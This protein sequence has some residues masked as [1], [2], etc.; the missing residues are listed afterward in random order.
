MGLES[1]FDV[2]FSDVR[3]ALTVCTFVVL[4]STFFVLPCYSVTLDSTTSYTV[5]DD[6][7]KG[8]V[9]VETEPPPLKPWLYAYLVFI[10]LALFVQFY[11][12][13]D[14]TAALGG[15]L[16]ALIA[17]GLSAVITDQLVLHVAENSNL[18]IAGEA[19]D[20]KADLGSLPYLIMAFPAASILLDT[21]EPAKMFF[22]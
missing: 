3:I 8:L 4:Y 22:T 6:W 7:T 5:L 11:N 19:N 1:V 16:F 17:A 20:Q 13:W 18:D 10:T 12:F 21:F 14:K 2:P 15:T 9:S